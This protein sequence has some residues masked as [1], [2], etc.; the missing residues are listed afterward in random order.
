[1]AI[2]ENETPLGILNASIVI[3]CPLG[4]EPPISLTTIT[5]IRIR[6]SVT[7]MPS[8]LSSERVAKRMSPNA[9]NAMITP[10]IAAITK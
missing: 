8:M 2:A 7:E 3:V 1:M 9:R 4:A 5:I 10:A 6:I